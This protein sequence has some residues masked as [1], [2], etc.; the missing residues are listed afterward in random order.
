MITHP[1]MF[2]QLCFTYFTL[3]FMT[4]APVSLETRDNWKNIDGNRGPRGKLMTIIIKQAL[5][6]SR[7]PGN[8]YKEIVESH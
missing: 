3:Q 7:S 5:L 4:E 8:C 2:L 6:H 1:R